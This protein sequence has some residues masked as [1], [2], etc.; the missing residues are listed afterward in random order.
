MQKLL[1]ISALVY[2]PIKINAQGLCPYIGPD[3]SLPCGVN[4][5]TLTADFSMCGPG[6]PAPSATTSYGLTNI[7]FAP[8]STVGTNIPLT[9]D[10]Q[11]GPFNIGFSFCFFGS[12]YTQFY[13]GSNGWVSFS[14]GQSTAWSCATIPI[15]TGNA[16]V[17]KNCIMTPYFDFTPS[18]PNHVRY[19]TIG[20]APCRKLVVSWVNVPSFS[21]GGANNV[22][23]V[24]YESTNIIET[25]ITNKNLCGGWNSGAGV[26]GIHNLA[27]TVAVTVPGRNA[28]S[29]S[30]TN[31]AY[32]WTPS[33]SPVSPVYTWYQVGNPVPIGTGLTINVTPPAGGAQYTCHPEY[34]ACYQG[35]MTCM[36]FGGA[37]GPDTIL[38]VP[39][40]PN[41][42][43]TIPGPYDFCPGQSITV[44]ADQIYANYVWSDG[45]TGTTMTTNIPGP[46]SVNITD[47]NGCTGTANAV[48][49]QW[50]NPVINVVPVNPAICPGGTVQMTAGGA[51]SYIWSPGSSLDNPNNNVVN[52][53]PTTTTIYSIVGTDINGCIDSTFNTV[54]VLPA[55]NVVANATAPG[56]C[57]TFGT[58]VNA[59]GALNYVWSPA[60]TI[61]TPNVASST[62]FPVINTNYQVIGTDVN[63]CSDTDMVAVQVYDLPNVNFSAPV[64]DGCSPV[65]IN[66]QDNSNIA[67][68]TIVNYTWNVES[69]GTTNVQNPSFTFT[70]PGAYDV[71]L[72]ATSNNGCTST[73]S[74]ID[75][76]NVY[77][78]PVAGFYAT[79][80]PADL[81]NA[82][83]TFT[84]TSTL[85]AVN[86]LWDF[87]GLGNSSLVSP[88]FQFTYA[89]TFD[90]TLYVSTIHG[91]MDTV[92]H[93]VIVEDVSEIWIP[94][95]FTPGNLDGLNDSWF[96]VGRNLNK[97]AIVIDVEVFDR[98]G[99]SVFKSN[100]SDKPWNGKYQGTAAECPQD[101][102][103][104]RVYF[105]NEKGEDKTYNGSVTLIR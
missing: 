41:I 21:C 96:P 101:V 84:N 27:G 26:H 37:N 1:L 11:A 34:G 63:G 67:S 16:C 9:D 35:Y 62:V 5:T 59:V 93:P 80:Q 8:E 58:T 51:Q 29:W 43:P 3:L 15:P 65:T 33:G 40:P 50:P 91:C 77:S 52:A 102:Y 32:R 4:N 44:G 12:T 98:W 76:I 64:T 68:G 20:V 55:P 14:A 17:P 23:I 38:V 95:G 88:S 82:L 66:L 86:F 104:Y 47:V 31:N 30:T 25:H 49:N 70:T 85:D 89:D 46:I 61:S 81:S 72:T 18:A 99:I 87:A 2:L 79:P 71:Q 39:G 75:Y 28:T 24:L 105:K 69:M 94:G 97:S 103:V 100:S 92:T 57:P 6:G 7:P 56:V 54:T 60:A 78:I 53:T 42:F 36:G 73:L 48:L 10:S 83:V 22:Q 90:V 74:I 45:S 13:V 19:Q